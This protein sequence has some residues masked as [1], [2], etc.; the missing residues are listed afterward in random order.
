[1]ERK[2]VESWK[3]DERKRMW[4]IAARRRKENKYEVQRK[5]KEKDGMWNKKGR[6]KSKM[7]CSNKEMRKRVPEAC[8]KKER[9]KRLGSWKENERKGVGS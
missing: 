2:S 8:K 5:I 1:M 3:E 7:C 9:R 4:F 6:G